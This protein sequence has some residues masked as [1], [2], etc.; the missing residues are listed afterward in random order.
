MEFNACRAQHR[1]RAASLTNDLHHL[2]FQDSAAPRANPEVV[3]ITAT[4]VHHP[5]ERLSLQTSTNHTDHILELAAKPPPESTTSA[6]PSSGSARSPLRELAVLI[7]KV[8]DLLC[9]MSDLFGIRNGLIQ[10][11]AVSALSIALHELLGYRH[12][13]ETIGRKPVCDWQFPVSYL[14]FSSLYDD[15]CVCGRC[16]VR[17][18]RKKH[19]PVAAALADIKR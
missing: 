10:V 14:A 17:D 1:Q 3:R 7:L 16:S 13:K 5:Q 6:R 18:R 4:D 11:F 19:G 15:Q 2:G 9:Q 12:K 8:D